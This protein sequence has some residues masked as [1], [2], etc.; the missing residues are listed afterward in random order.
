MMNVQPAKLS[1]SMQDR[2]DLTGIEK[3]IRIKRAFQS[4]LL[5]Q[6]IFR[7]HFPHQVTFFNPNT[8]FTRQHA[9]KF[10]TSLQDSRA[11]IFRPL[12]LA[13]GVGI[14]KYQRMQISITGMEN[15][16]NPQPELLAH[17]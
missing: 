4:L 10:N 11:K 16:G 15:I 12:K 6:I 8:V 1:A 14:K 5:F 7:E 9:A 3:V 17:P 13:R 2:E